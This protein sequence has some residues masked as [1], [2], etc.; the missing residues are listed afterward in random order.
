MRKIMVIWYCHNIYTA[1][2]IWGKSK[3]QSEKNY[4]ATQL[5]IELSIE[6]LHSGCL[7]I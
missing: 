5:Y 3:S 1:L 7:I 2:T 4:E 6:T